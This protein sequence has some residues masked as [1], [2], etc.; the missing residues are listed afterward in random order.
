MYKNGFAIFR[1]NYH[2]DINNKSNNNKHI[3]YDK[4]NAYYCHF[5][6]RIKYTQ[7]NTNKV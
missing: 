2:S 6:M 3:H 7:S 5:I 4:K 1:F